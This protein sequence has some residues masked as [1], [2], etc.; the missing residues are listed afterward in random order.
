M[1]EICEKPKKNH[2]FKYFRQIL[3]PKRSQKGISSLKISENGIFPRPY[4]TV[5]GEKI[6]TFVLNFEPI[7]CCYVGLKKKDFEQY[8]LEMLFT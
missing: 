7:P 3:A 8:V 5:S 6:F 1:Y 2:V 4:P